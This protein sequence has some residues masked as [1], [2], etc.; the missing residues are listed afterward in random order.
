MDKIPSYNTIDNWVRKCGLDHI[1]QTPKELKDVDYAVVI[2]ECMMIGSQ[3]LL[4]I[5]SVPAK[6]QGRPIQLDDV[7]VIG[8]DV[9][10][11]WNAE[12]VNESL[13]KS[14]RIIGKAPKYVISDNDMK[15]RKAIELSNLTWHRDISHTLAMFMER[16]YKH[17]VE[18]VNFFDKM[19]TCKKQC[20]MKDLAYLQSPSQ[21]CKARFMNLTESVN[22]AYKMLQLYHER[23][24]CEKAVFSFIPAYASFIDEIRDVVS[25][26]HFIEKEAKN[27]G[28]SKNTIAICKKH[29]NATIMCGNDRM[30][31]VANYFLS[32]LS[33]E[34]KL[35]KND[36]VV[37]NSSD[38]I[39]TTFG[40][41]KYI[42]SPN[43][44]NGVTTLVLH[45]PVRLSYAGKSKSKNYYVKE[46]LCRTRIKDITLWREKNLMEN[47]V[48]KRIKTLQTA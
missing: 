12:K 45:L 19:A 13:Q 8:F 35:L 22:W 46:R 28:L 40:I 33:E 18:F 3:K 11:N 37:N 30:R 17:D 47:L 26:V 2:D 36:E 23:N 21:R 29:V 14:E 43:K 15:M 24:A 1:N 9:Q 27:N 31:K 32:Y 7:K 41:F 20:C 38:I 5:I 10:S 4:P 44:L 6:H 48:A 39:E 34:D 42:Q 16:V 25:C